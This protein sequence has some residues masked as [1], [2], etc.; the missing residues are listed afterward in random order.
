MIPRPGKNLVP[1][2]KVLERLLEEQ[3]YF[4]NFV[5]FREFLKRTDALLD[6]VKAFN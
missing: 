5:H 6:M 1:D 3:I 4:K 2:V